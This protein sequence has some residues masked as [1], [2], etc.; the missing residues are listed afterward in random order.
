MLL[1]VSVAI[2]INCCISPVG[3]DTLYVPQLDSEDSDDSSRS[4]CEY[5]ACNVS[6]FY[7][8]DMIFSGA[9]TGSNSE[10]DNKTDAVFLPDNKFEES[11]LLC[12][13]TEEYMALPFLGENLDAGHDFDGRPPEETVIDDD[14]S[15]LYM[16]I[17]QLRSCNQDSHI[18]TYTDQDYECFDP[19]MYIR[20]LPDQPD[21][22][23]T[24]LPTSVSNEKQNAKQ[25]T[26]V[27]DLDG[28][29]IVL[30]LF[31]KCFLC[32]NYRII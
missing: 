16:A 3:S 4:S 7:I 9:P 6:D 10:F 1:K 26:L 32:L 19:Q 24:L 27:L 25:I 31:V 11:S 14:N 21:M 28:K 15:C 8:S 2:N 23:V 29:Y 17:H 30:Q 22:A 5:Q 12:D 20:S 18:N 13:F